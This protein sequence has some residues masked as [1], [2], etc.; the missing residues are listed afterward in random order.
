MGRGS[1][2]L[3]TGSPRN[4]LS[5]SEFISTIEE[6]QGLK[7]GCLE[8]IAFNYRWITKKNILKR[9][10]YYGNSEYSNYLKKI[11]SNV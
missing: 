11:I 3:D 5:T 9:I 2:W 4:L 6:R 10:K 7:V 8:E 1:A